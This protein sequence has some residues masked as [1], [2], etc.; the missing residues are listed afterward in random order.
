MKTVNLLLLGMIAAVWSTA[1]LGGPI[2][3]GPIH[4]NK[5]RFRIPF[6]YDA[7]EM[8]RLEAKEIRLYLSRDR[9]RTWQQVQN[10]SPES[11]KF[12]F[13]AQGDGDYWFAV[14]TIDGR[15]RLHPD[16]AIMEAGLQV[17]V[18]TTIPRLQLDLRQTSPGR[19]QLSWSASDENLDPTQLRL[20]YTQPGVD[21]QTLGVIPNASGQTEWAIPQGG[22]VSVRGS[23][24]D[25]ARNTAHDQV[26]LRV[27]SADQAVP[28]PN[29]PDLR[30][31]VAS[32]GLG[33]PTNVALSMPDQFPGASAPQVVAQAPSPPQ[34]EKIQFAP[35]HSAESAVASAPPRG[36]HSSFASLS[37]ET[38][39]EIAGEPR[40]NPESAPMQK[41]TGRHRIVS[42]RVF[43]IGYRLQDVGPSGVAGVEVY[44]TPDDGAT[45]YHYGT[46]SDNQSPAQIEVPRDGIYGFALGVRS[47]AGL[48]SE[49]TQAGDKP[50]IVVVVD[51]TPPQLQLMPLEQG[52]GRNNNKIL[53]K[54]EF[55]DE[56]PAEKPISLYYSPTGQAPWLPITGPID[57]TGSYIWT[58]GPGV[59]S[60]FH[61]KVEGRDIAG[62]VQ[63][64]E[65]P[66]AVL[67]DLS[68]PTAKIIDV[69]SPGN[70]VVPQ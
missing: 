25:F 61:V 30:Q 24:S 46:D 20:E 41:L 16:A 5:L 18:D 4:T 13:Q 43:Q 33:G 42:T 26:N 65:T 3:S 32:P 59:P 57:N 37:Q 34:E 14:R 9:G 10:V 66:Q 7:Q 29:T 55:T 35:I 15:G 47:G 31:P 48:T 6:H 67:I 22:N 53:I 64:A 11:A 2:P 28:R 52:R 36:P 1:A 45:W 54:W 17:I 49:P 8:Q 69:E 23:I 38:G 56:F 58:M 50:P 68:R 70:L 44:I 40:L 51:Q 63:T 62:N 60:R 19:V 27:G 21:W 12:N 39:P